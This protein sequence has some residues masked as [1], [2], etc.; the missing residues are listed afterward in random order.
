MNTN[1]QLP[2]GIDTPRH[3][4]MQ[5]V[6]WRDGKIITSQGLESP[7]PPALIESEHPFT[8]LLQGQWIET[9]TVGSDGPT[10]KLFLVRDVF[11]RLKRQGN[12]QEYGCDIAHWHTDVVVQEMPLP[13]DLASWYR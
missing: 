6:L 12:A 13:E 4:T 3:Y 11:H 5:F 2:P 10:P 7:F 8:P 1:E 9:D